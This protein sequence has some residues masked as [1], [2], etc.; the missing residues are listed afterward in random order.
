[1]KK[2]KKK[3]RMKPFFFFIEISCRVRLNFW[4]GNGLLA[5]GQNY[6]LKPSALFIYL[7]D[8]ASAD[9]RL[10]LHRYLKST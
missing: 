5:F 6:F 7:L 3:K 10:T 2:K 9:L 1:M 8:W 4:R